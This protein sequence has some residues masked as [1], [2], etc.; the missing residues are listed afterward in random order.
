MKKPNLIFDFMMI[1]PIYL[2]SALSMVGQSIEKTPWSVRMVES[3]MSRNN[4]Y[5]STWGYVE[6]T[7][8]KATGVCKV[9]RI[10]IFH[11]MKY[12]KDGFFC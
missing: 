11:S 7:V 9:I 1:L 8:L 5:N 2:F 10:R 4:P 3:E 6:G 12:V